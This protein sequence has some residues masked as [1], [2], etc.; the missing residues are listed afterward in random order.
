MAIGGMQL[1]GQQNTNLVKFY[2]KWV[3][4]NFRS[5]KEGRPVG[6]EVDYVEILGLGQ[7]K[8]VV[9]RAV[10]ARDKL[11]YG[12]QWDAYQRGLEQRQAGTP[13]EHWSNVT[14]EEILRLKSYNIHT[15]EA[16]RDCPDS[17]LIQ[18]GPGARD[19]QRRAVYYL[20][21]E[22]PKSA[23]ANLR[24]ENDELRAENERLTTENARLLA[25][26]E[27]LEAEEDEGEPRR[28]VGRPRKSSV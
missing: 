10:T 26:V 20:D 14:P 27:E 17:G 2:K 12:R 21:E 5:E 1:A 8:T 22:A 6:E 19:L 9:N 7:D 25:R 23:S 15:I 28:K 13:L 18:I 11:E 3:Q 4:N 16:L 24:A